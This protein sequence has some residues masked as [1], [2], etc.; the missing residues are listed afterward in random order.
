MTGTNELKPGEY[1]VDCESVLCYEGIMGG[2]GR[3]RIM[4]GT[5]IDTS[6]QKPE[7][8][9]MHVLSWKIEACVLADTCFL[10]WCTCFVNAVNVV[11]A[12]FIF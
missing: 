10:A 8:K 3:S 12:C 11:L 5:V 9:S 1:L 4:G 6:A 2:R 7:E